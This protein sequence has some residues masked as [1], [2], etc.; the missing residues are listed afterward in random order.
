MAESLEGSLLEELDCFASSV[1]DSPLVSDSFIK[2]SLA[3]CDPFSSTTL[4]FWSSSRGDGFSILVLTVALEDGETSSLSSSSLES[5]KINFF[6]LGFVIFDMGVN[7]RASPA[8]QLA[9]TLE[10]SLG[11]VE[12]VWGR[13]V[14]ALEDEQQ[15]NVNR[16][17]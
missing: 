9:S 1:T 17:K 10:A 7:G 15:S 2:Q 3:F 11:T 14:A 6:F 4:L 5:S 13:G 12:D 16:L 8:S